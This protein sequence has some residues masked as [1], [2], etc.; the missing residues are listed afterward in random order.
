MPLVFDVGD[1]LEIWKHWA[2]SVVKMPPETPPGPGPMP[3][4]VFPEIKTIRLKSTDLL[5]YYYCNPALKCNTVSTIPHEYIHTIGAN[6]D[7]YTANSP[8]LGDS[9]SIMNNGNKLRDRHLELIFLYLKEMVP[10]AR[11][12]L[13]NGTPPPF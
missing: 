9:Q 13:V 8:F 12:S 11:F 5:T 2:V 7:E 6:S 1:A 4:G 3:S 10:D